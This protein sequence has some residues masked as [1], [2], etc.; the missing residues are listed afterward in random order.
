MTEGLR[1]TISSPRAK[2]SLAG[3]DLSRIA[4][5]MRTMTVL[6]CRPAISTKPCHP[7]Y[8]GPKVWAST[9]ERT[10]Q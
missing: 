3:P 1:G 7:W 10:S 4:F 6:T 9:H 2:A 5:L 8:K